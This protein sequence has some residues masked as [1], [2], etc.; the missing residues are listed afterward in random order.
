MLIGFSMFISFWEM[1]NIFTRSHL[2]PGASDDSSKGHP[3]TLSQWQ[4][5]VIPY[6]IGPVNPITHPLAPFTRKWVSWHNI[7]PLI[8][9]IDDSFE[10]PWIVVL[11]KGLQ[12]QK[13]NLYP[14]YMLILNRENY[15]PFKN[16]PKLFISSGILFYH[17][18][19]FGL[20]F[21]LWIFCRTQ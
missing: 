13:A 4:N 7:I 6:V 10:N 3:I 18:F 5:W 9:S 14:K 16:I 12:T 11:E 21:S 2:K 15:G 8:M 19:R 20:M 1:M 17:E